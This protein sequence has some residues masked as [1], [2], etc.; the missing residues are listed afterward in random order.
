MG[1]LC[2]QAACS[3]VN[4]RVAYISK[5]LF[6]SPTE[7]GQEPSKYIFNIFLPLY[8]YSYYSLCLKSTLHTRSHCLKNLEFNLLFK[9]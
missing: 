7:V 6:C 2:A 5:L 4:S 8:F 1:Q 9:I 3:V